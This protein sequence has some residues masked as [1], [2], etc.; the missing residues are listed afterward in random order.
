MKTKNVSSDKLNI[1]HTN[2][3]GFN[4]KAVTLKT[5]L[6]DVDILT[7][8]E[9]LLNKNKE[10][11]LSGFTTFS[12]NRTCSSGGGI[13]T[14]VSNRISGSTLKVTE[15]ASDNEFII[16]RHSQFSPA[17]NVINIYGLQE[18]NL[19]RE[20]LDEMWGE[21]LNEITKIE[22]QGEHLIMLGDMN[23][24]VGDLIKGNYKSNKLG[25]GG[26]QIKR[27]IDTGKYVL[28][29]STDKTINGPY[30]RYDPSDP[31]NLE[32]KSI[33]DLCILS[34]ELFRYVH[35]LIIDD[36][37][38]RTPFHVV[39]GGKRVHSDHYSLLLSLEGVPTV[40]DKKVGRQK[41]TR[42]NTNK[43]GGWDAYKSLTTENKV[44]EE[45][46]SSDS[47]DANSLSN[48][49]NKELVSIKFK[50]FGKVKVGCSAPPDNDLEKLAGEEIDGCDNSL[51]SAILR[52]QRVQ[53]EAKLSKLRNVKS[54]KGRTAAV[55]DL[56]NDII[57][58]KGSASE[59]SVI[60]DNVTGKITA[61][62]DDIKRFLLNI[63]GNF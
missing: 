48:K 15:G 14:S 20:K 22:L 38:E 21:I 44:L 43:T 47:L 28:V 24:N 25:H 26:W 51:N 5:M 59:A 4:S 11:F 2:I 12:R 29:N 31:S 6:K 50:A 63:V 36:K 7:V 34:K 10:M 58:R 17:I 40:I 61:D 23:R 60:T 41:Q 18:S 16:T 35:S 56:K 9:T 57:G 39:S 46:A 52:Q 49:V 45:V 30:T 8:N 62:P 37:L 32:K 27:L 55:F 33:L 42:W 3:R 53:F 19:S 1:F 13:A 54:T